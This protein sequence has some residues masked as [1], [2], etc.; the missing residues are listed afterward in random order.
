MDQIKFISEQAANL[1]SWWQAT[2]SGYTAHLMEVQ[3]SK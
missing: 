3:D 2:S 1:Q